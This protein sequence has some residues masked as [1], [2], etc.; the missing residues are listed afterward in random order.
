MRVRIHQAR[1]VF[2]NDTTGSGTTNTTSTTTRTLSASAPS[3]F[4]SIHTR[5]ER[6]RT[7]VVHHSANPTYHD[8]FIFHVD[9]P[10]EDAL[11]CTLVA[12][13][14]HQGHANQNMGNINAPSP[15]GQKQHTVN[16]GKKRK[17]A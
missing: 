4:I 12:F 3:T 17:I 9:H 16:L 2:G 1:N 14:R 11:V 15:A 10:S 13:Q 7:R 6:S 8:E 5:N